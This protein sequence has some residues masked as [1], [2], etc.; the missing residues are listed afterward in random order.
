M[1]DFLK[2]QRKIIIVT[3]IL[4]LGMVSGIGIAIYFPLLT[5]NFFA[6]SNPT[7]QPLKPINEAEE[8]KQAL[9]I[10]YTEITTADDN[11]DWATLYKLVRQSVRDNL[12]EAQF[13]AYFSAQV[14]A[15]S[16]GE[17]ECVRRG[18]AWEP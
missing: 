7:F 6:N 12:T 3:S 4:V 18:A 13:S 5:A 2:R 17:E 1:K 15:M 16:S 14:E 10:F 9:A 8:K 11:Q